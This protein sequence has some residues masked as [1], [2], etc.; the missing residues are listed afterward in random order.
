MRGSAGPS[1][2]LPSQGSVR[3]GFRRMPF[4]SLLF[5]LVTGGFALGC[6]DPAQGPP[7]DAR[8]HLAVH[9]FERVRELAPRATP[10]G[11]LRR[12]PMTTL[13]ESRISQRRQAVVE[14]E[15]VSDRQSSGFDS[16]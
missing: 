5:A 8:L 9:L 15:Q 13:Q 10:A 7:Q 11:A 14:V 6:Q 1:A 2:R 16:R 4:E 3:N 12:F